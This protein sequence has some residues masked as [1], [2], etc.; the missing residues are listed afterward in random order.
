MT[1]SEKCVVRSLIAVA[2]ADGQIASGEL[3]VIEGMLCGFD[4]T[5]EEEQEMLEFARTPR[6]LPEDVPVG[7]L[8]REERELL[9]TNAA[10]LTLS[11]RVRTPSEVAVLGQLGE[12]LGFSAVET[13]ELVEQACA[14]LA[15]SSHP[16]AVIDY[17]G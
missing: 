7:E 3:G 11:D 17:S 9:L 12:L 4:A 2:W 8:S 14:G 1:P 13:A 15:A 6:S 16:P 5:T 10:L